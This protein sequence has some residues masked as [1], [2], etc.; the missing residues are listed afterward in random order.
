MCTDGH[1]GSGS[2]EEEEEDMPAMASKNR[3]PEKRARFYV[4]DYDDSVPVAALV[5]G[6]NASASSI[7]RPKN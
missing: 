4:D 1:R 3:R 5:M 7:S 2:E 6:F